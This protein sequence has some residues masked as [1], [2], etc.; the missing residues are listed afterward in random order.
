[1][2]IAVGADHAGFDLKELLRQRL[3][4]AGHEVEDL[5]TYSA[6]SVDYPDFAASV[7]RRV[8]SGLAE[9]GLLVCGSGV[10]MEIAANKFDGVR[11]ANLH[12]LEEARLAR[13]HNNANVVALGARRLSA[14]EAGEILDVFLA[15]PFDGGRHRR[16]IDKIRA[17]E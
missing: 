11:A 17:L 6:A 8:S 3:E 12:D 9:R 15:T 10:G 14:A 5:G 1:V 2:K 4:G 7:A 16:R 13:A